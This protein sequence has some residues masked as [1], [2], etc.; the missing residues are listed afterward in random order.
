MP[1][2]DPPADTTPRPLPAP[3]L[4]HVSKTFAGQRALADVSFD[5]PS[6]EITALLGMNGSGK[7]T[8]IKILAGV[9]EPDQGGA[10]HM[11]GEPVALPL[12]PAKARAHGLRFLHQDVG[13]VEALSI[14]DNFALVDRF[15]TRG[16]LRAIDRRAQHEHVARV[17]AFFGFDRDPG[18]LVSA[19]DPTTRTMV[20]VARA[21]QDQDGATEEA[22]AGTSSSSTNRPPPC[23]QKRWTRSCRVSKGCG[24]PV[25]PSSTSAT[26][27]TRCAAS[28]TGCLSCATDG[29]SGTSNCG[30]YARPR[31][32]PSSRS[33]RAWA[34]ATP[35]PPVEPVR[36]TVRP[37]RS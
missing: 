35:R 4:R 2:D 16:P 3:S 9:Y 32:S 17:L 18:T 13:L 11:A 8:L 22:S 28:P 23:P 12:R 15:R 6:G 30:A 10:L 25:A 19:L 33:R 34:S 14:A 37:V 29:S 7:S 26:A 21:F 1:A 31:S 24:P 36:A 20:G 5:V 27:P